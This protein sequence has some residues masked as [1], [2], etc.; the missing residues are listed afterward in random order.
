MSFF[1]GNIKHLRSQK[2]KSQQ[3]VADELS[4]TRARYS[5]YEEGVS[6]P[7]LNLLKLIAA[8]FIVSIDLL[9]SVDLKKQSIQE[10]LKLGNNRLLLPITVDNTG[11]DLIELVPQKA[12]A[13]YL[14]SYSDP[15]FIGSLQHI[16]LPFL[17]T[18][19]FRAFP[20]E[21]DS[22]PPHSSGT[23]IVGKFVENLNDLKSGKTYVILTVT[24]GIIYKR[25]QKNKLDEFMLYS[26]NPSF[27]P[28]SIKHSDIIEIWEYACSI[29]TSDLQA[30]ELSFESVKSMLID[31]KKD[32][33]ML[34]KKE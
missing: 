6:E 8:Y 32:I 9:I 2:N 5:K 23:F 12:R 14:S 21:G 25:L 34:R 16:S 11:E 19:K 10:L 4:I 29:S 30:D 27:N 24:E 28:Y 3:N 7:P 33:K 13:G 15:E 18:G 22:M 1:A 20:I 26:D 17:K 31:L